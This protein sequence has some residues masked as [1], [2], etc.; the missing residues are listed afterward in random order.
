MQRSFDFANCLPCLQHRLNPSVAATA[1]WAAERVA[2]NLL[3]G[4]GACQWWPKKYDALISL[5]PPEQIMMQRRVRAAMCPNARRCKDK[6]KQGVKNEEKSG[7]DVCKNIPAGS[8]CLDWSLKLFHHDFRSRL[9]FGG[10]AACMVAELEVYVDGA[11][12]MLICLLV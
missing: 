8:C 1:P 4:S 3:G 6:K 9:L 11:A 10:E 12:Y 5:R 7:K 2:Q